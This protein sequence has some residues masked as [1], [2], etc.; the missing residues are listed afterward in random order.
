MSESSTTPNPLAL[1]TLESRATIT[2]LLAPLVIGLNVIGILCCGYVLFSLSS[3]L[4]ERSGAA[5]LQGIKDDFALFQEMDA[6]TRK[7]TDKVHL[8]DES[9]D[10][11]LSDRSILDATQML[12]D[13]EKNAQLFLRL[14]K[15]NMY[16]LTTYIPGIAAWYELH[17]PEIDFAIERSRSRQLRLLQIRM[18]YEEMGSE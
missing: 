8:M 14:L 3:S 1:T 6:V 15:V 9:L 11:E 12:Q 5:L 4:H 16:N 2:G 10:I 7:S 18:L 17:S 13:T